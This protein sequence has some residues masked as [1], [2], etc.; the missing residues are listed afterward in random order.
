MSELLA[1]P[2]DYIIDCI[3]QHSKQKPAHKWRGVRAISC[4]YYDWWCRAAQTDRLK[5]RPPICA[6]TGW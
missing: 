1:E 6:K 5:F 2:F 4:L 3:G